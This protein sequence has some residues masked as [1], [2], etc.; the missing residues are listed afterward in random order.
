MHPTRPPNWGYAVSLR[1]I[2]HFDALF[3][4][5]SGTPMKFFFGGK[6]N[7]KFLMETRKLGHRPHNLFQ[8]EEGRFNGVRTFICGGGG[9]LML[10][11]I[12]GILASTLVG[13]SLISAC[14]KNLR[15]C[16]YSFWIS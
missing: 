16:P 2:D 15:S 11:Q 3:R 5:T 10:Q 13:F 12:L 1:E 4:I 9:G 6:L 8:P 7:Y 14:W